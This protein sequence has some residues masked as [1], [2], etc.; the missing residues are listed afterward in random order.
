MKARQS[1]RGTASAVATEEMVAA[2]E[3]AWS[4]ASGS[5]SRN[6]TR[7][8]LAGHVI[9]LRVAGVEL[10]RLLSAPL[11]HL[12]FPAA[13]GT[14]AGPDLRID[15]WDVAATGENPPV[16]HLRDV[17]HRTWPFGH[18]VLASTRDEGRVGFETH[19]ASTILDRRAGRIAGY[20]HDAARLSLYER[21]KPLQPLLLAWLSDRDVVPVHAGLVG[22][23]GAGLLLGGAG[24]S[25]KTTT[26]LLCA[27]SGFEYLGDDYIGLFEDESERFGGA[28]LYGSTWLEPAHLARFPWLEPHAIRGTE[29]EEKRLVLLSE[30]GPVRLGAEL[31]IRALVLPRVSGREDT[32]FRPISRARAV[33]RLAPSSVLQLPFVDAERALARMTSLA[34]SVAAWRLDL[35][36]D[37]DRISDRVEEILAEAVAS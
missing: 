2:F 24:G 3:R 20:V 33:L 32:T 19:A 17:F 30:V 34:G 11:A 29:R 7:V 10:A 21:G 16:E 5:G 31:G 36:T 28:S 9:E 37:L 15:L 18:N 25:G 1:R 6:V 4:R 22:R 27:R 8:R 23:D 14:D 13:N 35:G 12:A 26:A